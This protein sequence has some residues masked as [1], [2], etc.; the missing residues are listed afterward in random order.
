MLSA[1]PPEIS[2]SRQN[3]GRRAPPQHNRSLDI[4]PGVTVSRHRALLISRS[5]RADPAPVGEQAGISF[6]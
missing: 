5:V 4:H 3:A 6:E 2:L 1:S